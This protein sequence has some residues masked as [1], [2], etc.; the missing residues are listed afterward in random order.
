MPKNKCIV[1]DCEN[2]T[3]YALCYG[4]WM[5]ITKSE[6]KEIRAAH[7]AGNIGLMIELSHDAAK[8]IKPY[9]SD[10]TLPEISLDEWLEEHCCYDDLP[11]S[12]R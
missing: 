7:R 2:S 4:H 6:R 5:R 1:D 11:G 9:V 8:S 10:G 3:E 12:L